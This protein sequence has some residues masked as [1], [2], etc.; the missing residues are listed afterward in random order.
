MLSY[1]MPSCRSSL[2]GA[3]LEGVMGVCG[4]PPKYESSRLAG[5]SKILNVE[6]LSN[7]LQLANNKQFV[8][9]YIGIGSSIIHVA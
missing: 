5:Q 3:K 7:L 6:L 1:A 2:S 4:T 9:M 8:Y